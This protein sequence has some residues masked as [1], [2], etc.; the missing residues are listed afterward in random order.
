MLTLYDGTSPSTSNDN[1]FLRIGQLW[2]VDGH[3]RST[4]RANCPAF[5]EI[6]GCVEDSHIDALSPLG[7]VK[8]INIT[9]G[10]STVTAAAL[11]RLWRA[12]VGPDDELRAKRRDNHWELRMELICGGG[13]PNISKEG[14]AEVES[15]V[16]EN[17]RGGVILDTVRW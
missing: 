2:A 7:L 6:S 4:I 14:F 15:D 16:Y 11:K 5:K 17:F 13:F 12:N 10:T 3:L 8:E 9:S 1:H